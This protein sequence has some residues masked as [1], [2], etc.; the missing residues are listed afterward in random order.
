ME[1]DAKSPTPGT[2]ET[3]RELATAD[4]LRVMELLPHRYPFLLVDRI[5][6]I[7]GDSSC[8]G[9]KNVTIN[10]PQFTGHFPK[11]PVFPGVLLVEGMAQTAGAICCAHTLTRDTRP[12]RVY[13]MTI[14]KVKFRKPVVPGDTVEYHMRKLTNRRTM[15]WFRGEAKVAGTLVAEAEIG[16][17]LVTE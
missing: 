16:A 4:I 6:E 12:S 17:M 8:I 15:W 5:V 11:V 1:P 14:D 13:L 9:I 2:T 10:E 7:D 3:P